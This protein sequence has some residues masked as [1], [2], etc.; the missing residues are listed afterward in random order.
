MHY[1]L[2]RQ[3]KAQTFMIGFAQTYIKKDLKNEFN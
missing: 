2:R 3:P 1:W